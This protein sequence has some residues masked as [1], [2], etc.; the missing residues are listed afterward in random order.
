MLFEQG[1]I[2]SLIFVMDRVLYRKRQQATAHVPEKTIPEV[3][4]GQQQ[5]GY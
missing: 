4:P 3:T 1:F 2:I 5:W